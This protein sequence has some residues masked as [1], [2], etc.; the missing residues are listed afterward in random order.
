MAPR[1]KTQKTR[2]TKSRGNTVHPNGTPA[3]QLPLPPPFAPGIAASE[4]LRILTIGHSNHDPGLFLDLLQQHNLRT[5]VDVRSAPYS[6][7]APHFNRRE[8]DALLADANIA[9][10][11]AG[12]ALG[13]RPD[14]PA[15][16]RHGV[17]KPG[18]VNYTVMARQPWY[19]E[20]LQR[21]MTTAA[22][23]TTAI[24]CSEEDPRRCHR[25]RLIERTLREHGVNVEHIRG[26]GRLETIDPDEADLAKA[27]S[28]QLSLAGLHE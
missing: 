15:C 5:L 20:G 7:Y 18:N 1:P 3:K 23:G 22:C 14:D 24:M 12:D 4:P 27:P 9:Y 10:V 28:P 25:H 2:R 8:L 26:D 13:G 16:Y 19:Q 11:W 21:L 17:V 6:R